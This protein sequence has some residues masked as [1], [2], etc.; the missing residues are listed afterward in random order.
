[1]DE[2]K[3][4]NPT[5]LTNLLEWETNVFCFGIFVDWSGGK[6][7]RKYRLLIKRKKKL[8]FCQQNIL[9]RSW[10]RGILRRTKN[11]TQFEFSDK[12]RARTF[13]VIFSHFCLVSFSFHLL[14][15]RF[16]L[17]MK[18]KS[19]KCWWLKHDWSKWVME[20]YRLM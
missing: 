2:R 19:L 14:E 6:K 18:W 7:E 3:L 15:T 17:F 10:L 4:V 5:R 9:G 16:Q 20:H 8:F 1:M 13:V 11:P 12:Y